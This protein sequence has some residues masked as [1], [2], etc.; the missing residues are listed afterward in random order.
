MKKTIIFI[1]LI[2]TILLT[3]CS[4]QPPQPISIS[5][6]ANNT[7]EENIFVEIKGE[8]KSPGIFEM[9]NNDRIFHLIAKAGGLTNFADISNL[10]QLEKL[11]DNTTIIV[12][13]INYPSC[14]KN[15][16]K[17]LVEVRGEVYNPGVYELDENSRVFNVLELAG[18]IGENSDLGEISLTSTL[19]D[20]AILLICTKEDSICLEKSKNLW[21]NT[22]P[23]NPNYN[24]N[25]NE[26]LININT[27]SIS[28]L[29]TLDSIGVATAEKIIEYRIINGAFLTI[30]DIKNVNGI[31]DLTFEKIMHKITV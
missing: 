30:S 13:K 17:I 25:I 29:I 26:N 8:V 22:S 12:C 1:L 11:T 10:N 16:S 24:N 20:E 27:A 14:N 5:S 28:E 3:S 6:Q 18:G 2:F 21:N 15:T 23:I 19:S 4:N 9:S 7:L 31:G